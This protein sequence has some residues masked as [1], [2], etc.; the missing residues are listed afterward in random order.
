[1]SRKRDLQKNEL[2]AQA[3]SDLI[4][5]MKQSISKYEEKLADLTPKIQNAKE[6]KRQVESNILDVGGI[7]YRGKKEDCDSLNK[8]VNSL[9]RQLTRYKTTLENSEHNLKK[10]DLEIEKLTQEID[11]T[12]K[13][14]SDL[15]TELDKNNEA[16]E[17]ILQ[18]IQ[19]CELT[20]N[21][22]NQKLEERKIE[23]NTMKKDMQLLQEEEQKIKADLEKEGT[24]K[25][26]Y[27][28][29][30]DKMKNNIKMNRE[31]YKKQQ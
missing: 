18:E 3:E 9:E 27:K 23:F 15:Q 26:K 11:R 8:Q 31:K 21:D 16:G 19:A 6:R 29:H 30:C 17:K 5:D 13:H 25:Q 10:Y 20:K 14:I 12:D 2:E 7:D 24:Q 22:C 1:M 4:E 28:D